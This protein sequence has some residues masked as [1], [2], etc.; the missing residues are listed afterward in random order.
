MTEIT[1]KS[2]L[3]SIVL[4]YYLKHHDLVLRKLKHAQT[5]TKESLKIIE[6]ADKKHTQSLEHL[7]A[8]ILNLFEKFAPSEDEL[9]QIEALLGKMPKTTK[10]LYDKLVE[11]DKAIQVLIEQMSTD[12]YLE[13]VKTITK[14]QSKPNPMSGLGPEEYA[15]RKA[16]KISDVIKYAPRVNA[17]KG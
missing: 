2:D 8:D 6:A 11:N 1:G 4:S 5:A 14:I 13:A 17:K 12:T 10:E 15:L 7:W 3:T 9:F 16:T